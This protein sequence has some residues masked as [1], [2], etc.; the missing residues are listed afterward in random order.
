MFDDAGL[1]ARNLGRRV[2]QKLRV[3]EADVGN[4]AQFGTDDVRAV[5]PSAHAHFDDGHVNHVPGK[6]IEGHGRG[7]FEKG[8]VERLEKAALAR[9]EIGHVF[10][11]YRLSV[12]P[13]AFAEVDQMRRCV[14]SDTQSRGLEDGG[15]RVRT[16]AFAVRSGYVDGAE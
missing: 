1:F 7:Q 3:V 5:Q 9:H 11:R 12:Y 4:D 10:L 2:A 14:Q 13:Y 8:G 15:Q 6:P 16:R